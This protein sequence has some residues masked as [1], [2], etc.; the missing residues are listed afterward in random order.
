M[1]R[2]R[3]TA[4]AVLR[5]LQLAT[6][7]LQCQHRMGWRSHTER[8]RGASMDFIFMLTRND[9]TIEDADCLVDAACDLG[10]RTSASRMSACRPPRCRS[11]VAAIRRR[12][13]V[14]YLE[15][16]STTPRGDASV[17]GSG[18]GA[19][20]RPDSRRHRS[21]RPRSASSAIS[22]RY[23]PF[24]GRPVGHPTRLGGLGGAGR[25][26][27]RGARARSDAAASICS[28]IRAT[29]ADPLDLVR[30]ARDALPG[31]R[32]DRRRQRELGTSRFTRS[33]QPA[34]MRSRSARRCSTA[35]SR[36]PRD[37]SAARSSTSSTPATRRPGWR[38]E[39]AG[40][41]RARIPECGARR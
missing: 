2:C 26:A 3:G 7:V 19:R 24:P 41:P 4:I 38:H 21:S 12:G 35:R 30:A 31:G 32:A 29:E 18:A 20:R 36:P 1:N 5:I 13:G 11:C 9:R 16:V 8:F 28:R 10:V 15:V 39:R 23:F 6:A 33:P 14:C 27:L 17:A 34:S 40:P 37:R 22:S 25:R